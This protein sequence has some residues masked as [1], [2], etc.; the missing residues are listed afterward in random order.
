ME[1]R[2]SMVQLVEEFLR[3]EA[4]VRDVWVSPEVAWVVPRRAVR[5]AELDALLHERLGP[6]VP[7]VALVD[8][9]PRLDSGDVDAAALR[10]CMPPV[11][12]RLQAL[13]DALRQQGIEAVALVGTRRDE[14]V[15]TPLDALLP[16]ALRLKAGGVA[17]VSSARAAARM[18]A[19]G[20]PSLIDSGPRSMPA[21]APRT[22]VELLQQ[23]VAHAPEHV[24]TFIDVQGQRETLTFA[25][26]WDEALRLWGGLRA[27]GAKAGD[28]V[29][30]AMERPG[31]FVRG[32]WA[33]T[34]GGVVPV[35]LALPASLERSQPASRGSSRCRSG[36]GHRGCSRRRGP[37]PRCRRRGCAPFR[38]NPCQARSRG[39]SRPWTRR[40]P[41]SS[42]LRLGAP[43][44][45]RAWC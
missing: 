39:P 23:A 1:S 34:L 17:S 10:Q 36:W 13:E 3:A 25:A 35:P 41:P 8:A 44:V 38:C 6:D 42:P 14:E 2:A 24:I 9:L 43:G 4:R 30:L 19:G 20:R 7:A 22:L 28:R 26:L 40:R 27:R 21:G 45:P 11:P 15:H 18:D 31:D 37:R 32:F 5:A 16:A 33:C 12:A 29:M